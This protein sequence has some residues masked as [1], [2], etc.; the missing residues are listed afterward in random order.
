MVAVRA[1]RVEELEAVGELTVEAY[2]R[3]GHL[4]PGADYVGE[5][6]DAARR[7]AVA[8]L[9]VAAEADGA[10]VGTVTYCGPESTMAEVAWAG[11]AEFRMLAVRPAAQG[12]GVGA[13]LSAECVRRAQ[14]QGCRA[15][16]LCVIEGND[17]A[18]R[19]YERMGFTR[20]P[21]RDW[22]PLPDVALRAFRLAL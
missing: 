5:L 22:W 4:P 19:L 3:N 17:G 15:V 1:A 20:I 13:L 16:V 21:D 10:I 18:R 11:E 12:R 8:T 2:V 6:R 14:A 7:A 9:L